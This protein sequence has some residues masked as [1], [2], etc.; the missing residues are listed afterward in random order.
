VFEVRLLVHPLRSL[1]SIIPYH[2]CTLS[3]FDAIRRIVWIGGMECNTCITFQCEWWLCCI[4]RS[5]GVDVG[6]KVVGGKIIW[7]FCVDWWNGM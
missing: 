7:I 4:L 3:R 2:L 6:V 1:L 5:G